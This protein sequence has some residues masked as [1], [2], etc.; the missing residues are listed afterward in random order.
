MGRSPC[1][2]ES[3]LKKG[4]WTPEE[5]QKLVKYIQKHGHGSWRAL[6]RLA[7]LNRCGKSC[8]LR[9][10]NYLRPDIKRGKFSQEE[11]ETILNLHSILGN[12]WSAIASHLPGRTD[13]EIKNF[14][15]T[16]LKK[17][18]I[19][20]G[21][22]P[23]THRPRTDI[24][25]SLPHLIAL[26]NLKELIM[27]H[28]WEELHAMR[29]IQADQALQMAKLQYLQY[30]LQTPNNTNTSNLI[31]NFATTNDMDQSI[32]SLQSAQY[33][34][35]PFDNL[36]DLLQISDHSAPLLLNKQ[37]VV[38]IN[39]PQD[40]TVFSQGDD[41][42]HQMNIFTSSSSWI[43]PNSSVSPT[44]SPPSV[45]AAAVETTSIS[46]LPSGDACS[47]SSYGAAPSVWPDLLLDDTL[48]QEIA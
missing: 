15:N 14:W 27:D 4:P 23:M 8:R 48:F 47:A 34:S 18:L 11:E 30:L 2:D 5:D 35:V 26:A 3:G 41:D 6:P 7:G 22:D 36:P 16:H 38:D 25:S 39:H 40:F 31:N 28:P 46:N 32:N 43:N 13:N 12:K 1:C 17:K 24:F 21:I 44:P 19:Q 37:Q 10:T 33:D 29:S 20:M 45:A 42:L 9:W